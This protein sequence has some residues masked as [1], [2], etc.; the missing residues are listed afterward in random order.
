MITVNEIMTSDV[1]SVEPQMSLRDAL[2][3]L[4]AED[5][6]GAPVVQNGEVVGVVSVTDLLEFEATSPGVPSSRPGQTE[7]GEFESPDVWEEGAESP[8]AFF[9]DYWSD[10]GAEV[11]ERFE[12]S[13][14]PEWD[15]LGE[16]VVAEV[17]T[18]QVVAL[19][20]GSDLREAAGLMLEADVHRIL[21]LDDGQLHGIVTTMDVVRAVAEERL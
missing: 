19:P 21:V 1:A 15:A 2:E 8:S 9:V 7:W 12:E 16:H 18:R 20:P 14:S 11:T 6:S 4:R 5:V 13:D 17:M 3:V 10:V